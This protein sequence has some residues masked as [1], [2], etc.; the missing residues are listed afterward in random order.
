MKDKILNITIKDGVEDMKFNGPWTGADIKKLSV[1]IARNYKL[2]MRSIKRT[3]LG[4]T[5]GPSKIDNILKFNKA[6][7]IE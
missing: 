4:I 3:E 2:Y 5:P 6:N 7:N 1:H